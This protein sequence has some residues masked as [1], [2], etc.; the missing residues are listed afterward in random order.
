MP[1]PRRW[2]RKLAHVAA[3]YRCHCPRLDGEG[4]ELRCSCCRKNRSRTIEV[5]G[6]AS[7][8]MTSRCVPSNAAAIGFA[9]GGAIAAAKNRGRPM[10]EDRCSVAGEG[11]WC[12]CFARHCHKL[13]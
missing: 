9:D 8:A 13:W 3:S 4:R 2:R 7:A 10:M 5:H 6:K 12:L 1:P 11:W